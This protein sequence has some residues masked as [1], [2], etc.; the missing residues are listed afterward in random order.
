MLAI[1]K[2]NTTLFGTLTLTDT[3]LDFK[4]IT[5][6][7]ISIKYQDITCVSK[8]SKGIKV[9][10]IL[11]YV[12]LKD[13]LFKDLQQ[14]V[15]KAH[16][17]LSKRDRSCTVSS[18]RS[19][20][21]QDDRYTWQMVEKRSSGMDLQHVFYE[22]QANPVIIMPFKM[23]NT[24]T[25]VL[26]RMKWI[27]FEELCRVKEIRKEIGYHVQSSRDVE[28]VVKMVVSCLKG[29][30]LVLLEYEIEKEKILI[31]LK[32]KQ[33]QLGTKREV[34]VKVEYDLHLG[35]KRLSRV[36]FN[37]EQQIEQYFKQFFLVEKDVLKVGDQKITHSD[38][39]M[40][41][42]SLF[43]IPSM[44]KLALRKL[45]MQQG[46]LLVLWILVVV[47]LVSSIIVQRELRKR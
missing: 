26:N 47:G 34:K 7:H 21:S 6:I 41:P 30:L 28:L 17:L 8:V 14:R 10:Q 11:V 4:T 25:V 24:S 27:S 5:S 20:I 35:E 37:V 32:A 13:L 18:T 19:K 44:R 16:S 12:V 1:V 23:G 45:E 15:L 2:F 33:K 29:K 46:L 31:R 40:V 39:V 36:K 38:T 42:Q 22:I 3:C 9:D 43:W